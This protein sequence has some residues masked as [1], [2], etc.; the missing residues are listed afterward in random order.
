MKKNRVVLMTGLT[1]SNQ[2]QVHACPPV[3]NWWVSP[4]NQPQLPNVF[5]S[6]ML[7]YLD[8]TT[9]RLLLY[10]RYILCFVRPERLLLLKPKRDR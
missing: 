3:P 4:S 5:F 9:L 1:C 8:G 6:L 10:T 2:A 7:Y